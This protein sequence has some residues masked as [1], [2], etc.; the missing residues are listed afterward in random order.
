MHGGEAVPRALDPPLDDFA[1]RREDTDVTF[2][3]R[4]RGMPILLHGWPIFLRFE[5]DT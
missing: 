3:H 1:F 2:P 4:A 5:R